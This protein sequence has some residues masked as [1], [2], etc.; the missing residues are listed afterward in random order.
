MKDA[1]S[2]LNTLKQNIKDVTHMFDEELILIIEAVIKDYEETD[3]QL[4]NLFDKFG[5]HDRKDLL[6]IL[7]A[8]EILKETPE[9]A[10]YVSIYENAYEM[11][12]DVKGFRTNNSV[13]ELQQMFDILKAVLKKG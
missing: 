5:I 6:R 4:N 13:E 2:A 8:I 7:K 1:I 11:V 12:S 10:W 9:F 3:N